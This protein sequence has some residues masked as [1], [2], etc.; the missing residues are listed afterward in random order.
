M[1]QNR[2]RGRR[3]QQGAALV[4]ALISLSMLV[5][6]CGLI[7][8]LHAVYTASL[9]TRREARA[10]AWSRALRGCVDNSA[11]AVSLVDAL[12]SGELPIAGSFGAGR[13][14]TGRAQ[15]SVSGYGG[16]NV[17]ITREVSLPCN[18]RSSEV[19]NAEGGQ[20]VFDLFN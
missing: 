13:D 20:W 6:L 15:R 18:I 10:D 8:F 16:H 2:H 12:R 1:A 17:N 11:D 7:T 4:E 9:Q 14:V 5:L 3:G 19:G